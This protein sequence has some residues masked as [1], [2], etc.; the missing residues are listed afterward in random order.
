[1]TSMAAAIGDEPSCR[2]YLI[3]A[4]DGRTG[5]I[6]RRG[7]SKQVRLLRWWLESGTI[8]PGQWLKGRIYERRCD[9]SPDGELLVYFAAKWATPLSTWTAI[10][11][12]PYLTA[13]ALWPHGDAWGG[14]GLF[15][16]PG[17]LGLNHSAIPEPIV[18]GQPKP[19]HPLPAAD[20]R[21]P[22]GLTVSPIADW[23]GRGEDS[24]IEDARMVRDGWEHVSK[25]KRSEYGK[26]PGYAWHFEAPEIIQ[27]ASP[28]PMKSAVHLRRLLRAIGESNGPWNVEDFELCAPD[29]TVLRQ[30]TACGWADWLPNGD[31]A[32][33]L[34]GRLYQLPAAQINTKTSDP[35]DGA[36]LIA[37]LSDMRFENIKAPPQAIPWP[38]YL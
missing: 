17:L 3:V 2:L 30:F 9:L 6:F 16:G 4:R 8:E 26:V 38:L 18:P 20:D 37:D 33:A 29:G 24:P 22:P 13:L 31:L 19:W 34:N 12:P 11:R 25:G 5:V 1:M 10:S 15:Y 35:T 28:R 7:P 32:F 14:G 36:K 23:A 27:R 21:L